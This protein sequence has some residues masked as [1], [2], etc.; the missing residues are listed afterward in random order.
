MVSNTTTEKKP[1]EEP[2]AET[3]IE[4]QRAKPAVSDLY[5]DLYKDIEKIQDPGVKDKARQTIEIYRNL[6]SLMPKLQEETNKLQNLI[7]TYKD[8]TEKIRNS[9][10]GLETLLRK[11]AELDQAYWPKIGEIFEN[12]KKTIEEF[13]NTL[14]TYGETARKYEELKEKLDNIY[15]EVNMRVEKLKQVLD[16]SKRIS[17][18]PKEIYDLLAKYAI[19]LSEEKEAEMVAELLDY[20]PEKLEKAIEA[21][22]LL[23]YEDS[24]LL[25]IKAAYILQS[26]GYSMSKGADERLCK[27]LGVSKT[28]IDDYI[29]TLALETDKPEV[30]DKIVRAYK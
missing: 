15:K 1:E 4:T 14:S 18:I 30:R 25:P 27:K 11:L 28:V 8:E 7:K 3:S 9:T 2:Q 29:P 19:R 16:K 10:E 20:S 5:E 12:L 6:E 24:K 26:G 21:A 23:G 17:E 13:A 22:E